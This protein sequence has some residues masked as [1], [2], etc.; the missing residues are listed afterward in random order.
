MVD[1]VATIKVRFRASLRTNSTR[2]RRRSGA[3]RHLRRT[4]NQSRLIIICIT[5]MSWEMWL[6]CKVLLNK[7][8]S[9]RNEKKLYFKI[10]LLRCVSSFRKLVATIRF[11]RYRSNPTMAVPFGATLRRDQFKH[12]R[13][14]GNKRR[15]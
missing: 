15:V 3:I 10:F 4:W 7:L 14:G 12:N 13:L 5:R 2:H 9:N 11:A 8:I 6:V 1:R